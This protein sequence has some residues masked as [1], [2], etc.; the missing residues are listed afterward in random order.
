MLSDP[1]GGHGIA[2]PR[3]SQRWKVPGQ[4]MATAPHTPRTPRIRPDLDRPT[5][6]CHHPANRGTALVPIARFHWLAVS[7]GPSRTPGDLGQPA[8]GGGITP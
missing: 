4:P 2:P 7:V 1:A 6:V 5:R 8:R 3:P